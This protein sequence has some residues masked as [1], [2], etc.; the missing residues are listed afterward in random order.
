MYARLAR[1]STPSYGSAVT[2]EHSQYHTAVMLAPIVGMEDV[3]TV[4]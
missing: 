1:R 3:E 2:V 4:I